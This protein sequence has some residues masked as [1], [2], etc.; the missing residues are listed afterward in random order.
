MMRS[1]KLPIS[2][3]EAANASLFSLRQSFVAQSHWQPGDTP[4]SE[5]LHMGSFAGVAVATGTWIDTETQEA[6]FTP[7]P[8]QHVTMS[9]QGDPFTIGS[10]I[11]A[12]ELAAGLAEKNSDE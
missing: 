3:H 4:S 8:Q 10:A 9:G 2:F 5:T 12:M 1:P 6:S 7:I 11:M